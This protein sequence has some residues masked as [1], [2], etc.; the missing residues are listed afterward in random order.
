MAVGTTVGGVGE[1]KKVVPADG[2]EAPVVVLG[3][4]EET[5]VEEDLREALPVDSS[6]EEIMT[7]ITAEVTAEIQEAVSADRRSKQRC[8]VVELSPTVMCPPLVVTPNR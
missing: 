3:A 2:E 1:A 7:E 6:A 4:G 5:L 8:I